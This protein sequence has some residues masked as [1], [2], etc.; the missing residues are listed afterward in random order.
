MMQNYPT[1]EQLA[2]MVR[3]LT[4]A[5][6]E[7]FVHHE[8]GTWHW[9]VLVVLLI[10]PW[11]VWYKLA[12]KKRLVELVMFGLIVMVYTITLDE[13]GFELS[14]WSYPIEVIPMFPRLTSADYTVIPV[15]YMLT[16]QCFSTWKSFFWALVGIS[17]VFSFLVEPI[18]VYLGFYVIIKWAHWQ[19]FIG[20]IIMGLSARWIARIIM[21]VTRKVND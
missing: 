16:Y 20:Y 9:W 4:N 14:L 8:V 13:L 1:D 11:F 6:I 12:D 2:E 5:R 21:D 7:H 10:I 18:I 3:L 17:A 15:I 19:S